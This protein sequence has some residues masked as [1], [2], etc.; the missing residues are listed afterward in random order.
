MSVKLNTSDKTINENGKT[1]SAAKY[2]QKHIEKVN[3]EKITTNS[4]DLI[5]DYQKSKE[6]IYKKAKLSFV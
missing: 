1:Y 4:N 6:D 2:Y 5:K 3:S